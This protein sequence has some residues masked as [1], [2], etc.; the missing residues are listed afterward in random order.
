MKNNKF[1]TILTVVLVFLITS[2]GG[3]REALEGQKRSNE[4]DEFLVKKKNPLQMP[5]D[6]D[7]MPEPGDGINSSEDDSDQD[8][9]KILKLKNPKDNKQSNATDSEIIKNILEKI[10]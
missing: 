4:S 9:K 3:V 6:I 7:K 1:I 2:C 10:Q 8:V 5:P